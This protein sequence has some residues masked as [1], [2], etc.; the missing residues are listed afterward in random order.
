MM[1]RYHADDPA[2]C[3]MPKAAL[4]LVCAAGLITVA[5]LSGCM[6]AWRVLTRFEQE[7]E[8]WGEYRAYSDS[9]T[10]WPD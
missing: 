5:Y 2:S 8:G 6:W 7:H 4:P 3:S 9:S 1:N 10:Q